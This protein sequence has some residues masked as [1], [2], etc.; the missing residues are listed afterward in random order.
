MRLLAAS[1]SSFQLETEGF[2]SHGSSSAGSVKA[3]SQAITPPRAC[4]RTP[5]PGRSNTGKGDPEMRGHVTCADVLRPAHQPPTPGLDV[6]IRLSDVVGI[7]HVRFAR[8]PGGAAV[9]VSAR[10]LTRRGQRSQRCVPGGPRV[11]TRRSIY[12]RHHHAVQAHRRLARHERSRGRHQSQNRPGARRRRARTRHRLAVTVA[13]STRLATQRHQTRSGS[14]LRLRA[15]RQASL[16]P[17]SSRSPRAR[18]RDPSPPAPRDGRARFARV[19]I[20]AKE[21]QRARTVR[22]RPAKRPE[23]RAAIISLVA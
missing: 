22:R 12:P 21:T 16:T 11:L 14:I 19:H 18:T 7:V 6:A 20:R 1:C 8:S 9:E 4:R 13:R 5:R 23:R 17:S 3:A 15:L 2:R 10:Y